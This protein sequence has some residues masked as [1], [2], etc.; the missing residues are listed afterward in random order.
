MSFGQGF[1]SPHFHQ[2][3]HKIADELSFFNGMEAIMKKNMD[4]NDCIFYYRYDSP[5][6]PIYIAQDDIGICDVSFEKEK[7][8]SEARETAL[9]K[10][11]AAELEDYFSGR[12]KIFSIA[13]SINGTSFQNQ[14]WEALRQIPYGETK[15]YSQIAEEIGHPL[16]ARAVGMA[17]NKNRIAILLPCHRVIGKKGS[18]VGY[19]GGLA[20]KKYLLD[21]EQDFK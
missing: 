10:K 6:G 15:Y 3:T 11:T 19:A 7:W 9:I 13:L 1:D 2:T 17:N 4:K 14:V 8:F 12:R 16:A 20:I 18:L 5:V 21:L